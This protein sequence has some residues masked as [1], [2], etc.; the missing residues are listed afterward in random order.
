MNVNY[1]NR[2][3]DVIFKMRK[4]SKV[5]IYGSGDL[6][7][8]IKRF[9]NRI[10]VDVSGYAVDA[11]YYKHMPQKIEGGDDRTNGIVELE[12][13]LQM[14]GTDEDF[15]LIWGIASPCK[16]RKSL[17]ETMVQNVWITYDS[18]NFWTDHAFADKNRERFEETKALFTDETSKKTMEAYLSIFD[19]NYQEAVKNA[20]DETYFNELTQNNREGCFLDCG[21]FIG[22]S[23]KNYAKIYGNQRKIYAFEPDTENYKRLKKN[24]KGLN[25]VCVNAGCWS[26]SGK[27]CFDGDGT[28][29]SC[30]SEN[31]NET[32][33]VVSIDEIV[34]NNKVA[35]VKMDIEGSELEALKGMKDILKR[36]M[37]ILAIS[38]YHRQEDLITLPQYIYQ[39]ESEDEYYKLYLRHHGC[40]T[41]AELVLYAIP[42]RK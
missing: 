2:S 17:E 28:E 5:Y 33:D 34:A 25:I 41:T 11:A 27:L 20:V 21:A 3:S 16:F 9:L 40:A 39:F 12:K 4:S 35:F 38:A 14:Y 23:V 7:Q 30:I 8:T 13:I 26:E 42:T 29:A 6:G 10:Q 1:F 24:T 37:P 15:Y 22:N 32:V 31:G 19:Y 36:D 18:D